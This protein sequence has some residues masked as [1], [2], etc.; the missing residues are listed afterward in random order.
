MRS[1]TARLHEVYQFF[2]L[3][4]SCGIGTLVVAM[5]VAAKH[6]SAL[7]REVVHA[8]LSEQQGVQRSLNLSMAEHY[9]KFLPYPE[10]T[11]ANGAEE[12]MNDALKQVTGRPRQSLDAWMPQGRQMGV[13]D[14]GLSRK[15]GSLSHL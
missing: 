6:S 1:H 12:R 13:T 2:S 9:A 8:R 3:K 15:W 5:Q 10:V 14:L 4:P 11:N 7:G